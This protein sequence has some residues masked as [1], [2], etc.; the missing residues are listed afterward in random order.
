M[1]GTGDCEVSLSSILDDTSK[2]IYVVTE[3]LRIFAGVALGEYTNRAR[4]CMKWGYTSHVREQASKLD[5]LD[6]LLQEIEVL[7]VLIVSC[8]DH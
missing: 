7:I 3:N 4:F 8:L 6:S 1:C 5:C 2:S